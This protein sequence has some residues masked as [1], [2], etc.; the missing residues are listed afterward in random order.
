MHTTKDLNRNGFGNHSI[1]ID[2]KNGADISKI[3]GYSGEYEVV[4]RPGE[5]KVK[6]ISGSYEDGFKLHLIQ[7]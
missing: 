6:G 4:L 5:F 1:I 3:S 2:A 7:L